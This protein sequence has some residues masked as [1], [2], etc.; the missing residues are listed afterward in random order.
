M[1]SRGEG[2]VIGQFIIGGVLIIS[3]PLTRLAVPWFV[4]LFGGVLIVAGLGIGAVAVLYLGENLS[5]LPKP[6][7]DNHSLVTSGAYSLVRHPIYFGI[8]IA[9]FGWGI[10][11][12]SLIS[13]LC[14]VA[15]LVW[16][17]LKS[18]RE[19]QWLIEQYPEYTTYQARVKKL[20]PFVY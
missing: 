12:G 11:W 20:I 18:R 4:M 2:W 7:A 19:E 10:L 1:G 14:T 13:I 3:A 16:F 5:P 17:D 15:L 8:L 9:G 6:R